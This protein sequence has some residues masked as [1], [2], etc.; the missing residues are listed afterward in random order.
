MKKRKKKS[1]S[2]TFKKKNKNKNKIVKKIK[3]KTKEVYKA[4]TR[5][6]FKKKVKK[7]YQKQKI[8]KFEKED[9]I[10]KLVKFQLSIKPNFS[11]KLSLNIE[12]YIQSFF[13]KI[14][15]TISRYQILK[16]D[17]KRKLELEKIEKER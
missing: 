4:K 16:K 11:F 8:K 6:K 5:E 9:L 17:Q 2:N 7:I 3:K 10:S 13:D 1:S 12:K 15:E 14:S